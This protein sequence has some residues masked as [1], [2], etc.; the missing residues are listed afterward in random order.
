MLGQ[1][2]ISSGRNGSV[3]DSLVGLFGGGSGSRLAHSRLDSVMNQ[4]P[5]ERSGSAPPRFDIQQSLSSLFSTQPMLS[6][7]DSASKT[8]ERTMSSPLSLDALDYGRRDS[9]DWSLVG[10]GSTARMRPSPLGTSLSNAATLNRPQ[11]LVD[12]FNQDKGSEGV[13]S[14]FSNRVFSSTLEAGNIRSRSVSNMSTFEQEHSH[15]GGLNSNALGFGS[16]NNK[17]SADYGRISTDMNGSGRNSPRPDH[18]GLGGG[19]HA[20]ASSEMSTAFSGGG[21]AGG[22]TGGMGEVDKLSAALLGMAVSPG[23]SPAG[24]Q[25]TAAKS[26]AVNAQAHAQG[27]QG[28]KAAPYANAYQ[29][30]QAHPHHHHIPQQHLQQQQQQQH[31]HM[32]HL[33]HQQMMQMQQHTQQQQQHPQ[34]LA[35]HPH[36]HPMHMQ[37]HHMQGQ[38]IN[39]ATGEITNAPYPHPGLMHGNAQ[40]MHPGMMPGMIPGGPAGMYA[41]HMY[42]QYMQQPGGPGA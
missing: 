30:Q 23:D 4:E 27:L 19:V 26:P 15:L 8:F 3:D 36:P 24:N 22:I 39:P 29:M 5:H 37:A 16:A 14:D 32:Q 21:G 42:P 1:E 11:S 38:V 20:S 33:Q 25:A 13:R 7:G 17:V 9:L 18:M 10:E 35:G 40:M 2:G 12:I 28:H 6:T 31:M 34:H 41:P